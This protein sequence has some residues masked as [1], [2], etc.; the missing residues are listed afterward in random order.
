MTSSKRI[1]TLLKDKAVSVF[2][3]EFKSSQVMKLLL[4]L[5]MLSAVLVIFAKDFKKTK[6]ACMGSVYYSKVCCNRTVQTYVARCDMET[7]DKKQE[8]TKCCGTYDYLC[9]L[10]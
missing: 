3:N 9:D 6:C 1:K 2:N 7:N 8:Y 5:L 4:I 10:N